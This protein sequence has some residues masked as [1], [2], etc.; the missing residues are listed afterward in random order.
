VFEWMPYPARRCQIEAVQAVL[1]S[2][3][4]RPLVH[5]VMGSGKSCCIAELCSHP[6]RIVVS[7]PKLMLVEQLNATIAQAIGTVGEWSG[8]RHQLERVTVCCDDSLGTVP[9]CDLL[10]VDEAHQSETV[11]YLAAV[12]RLQPK[13]IVGFTATP[14]RASRFEELSLFAEMVYSYSAVE[15]FADGVCVPP[16]VESYS[17]QQCSADDAVA[18][19]VARQ[20]RQARPGIVNASNIKD[21]EA[22]AER[23]GAIAVHSGKPIGDAFEQSRAGR[24]LVHVNLLAEGSDLPWLQ[25]MALRRQCSSAVRFCQEVGRGLRAHPGKTHLKVFDPLDQWGDFSLS[26]SAVLNGM[27]DSRD[28]P[29]LEGI[30]DG[31]T[32]IC[33]DWPLLY[34]VGPGA[35]LS[36]WP[37]NYPARAVRAVC[38]S[39]GDRWFRADD[40]PDGEVRCRVS[41]WSG[42]RELRRKVLAEAVSLSEAEAWL[43]TEAIEIFSSGKQK[44]GT[45]SRGWRKDSASEKQRSFVEG[46]LVKASKHA[47]HALVD[48]QLRATLGRVL[49]LRRELSKGGTSDLATVLLAVCGGQMDVGG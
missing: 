15:A 33:S 30:S 34:A 31:R 40:L 4:P 35:K 10:I 16:R 48:T 8:E 27:S 38:S 46:L 20:A 3:R 5:M 42:A 44:Q 7:T 23:I 17:G 18:A 1:S 13:R 2:P 28:V 24:V 12:E 19:W 36:V 6:G 11:E 29:V 39:A 49:P 45:K 9:E 22:F 21:C 14:F 37:R 43:K 32:V 26:P 25:W 41:E 47:C